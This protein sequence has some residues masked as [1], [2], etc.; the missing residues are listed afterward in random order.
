MAN[1]RLASLAA[2]LAQAGID[3]AALLPSAG[4]FY[5]TGMSLYTSERPLIFVLLKNGALMSV[6]PAFE[7]SRIAREAPFATIF[8]YTDEE[9]AAAGFKR[10]VEASGRLRAL[11]M[12]YQAARLLEYLLLKEHCGVERLVDLRPLLAEQRMVKEPVEINSMQQAARQADLVMGFIEQRLSPGISETTLIAQAEAFIKEQGGK[13][14]FISIIGGERTALPHASPSS[15]E[16]ALGDAVVVDL[17]CQ[18]EGYC[19]DITRTF[20][21][22]EENG[23]ILHIGQIVEQANALARAAVYPGVACGDIDK[24][25]RDYIVQAGYG[26]YFTH[27]TGHGLG[28]EIHEEPYIVA[29]NDRPLAIGHTFTIEPGIYLPR[30]G[31]VRIEDDICVTATGAISLT[32]Y[33][34]AVRVVA[35][36]APRQG[37]DK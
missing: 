26:E 29:G 25:A 18:V 27:R 33:P 12:E 24:V 20:V 34:R 28:L 19:S 14:A 17:G 16:L 23:H 37:G 11:A 31:G 13:L 6:C 1:K 22:G 30:V 8:T 5:L 4:L 9:G 3:A 35:Q 10:L 36:S 32:T 21:L 15:R 2:K 7:A